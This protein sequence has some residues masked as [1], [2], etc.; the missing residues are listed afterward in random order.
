MAANSNI[1]LTSLDFDAL[2]TNF[3]TYLQGQSAFKDY[4]FQGS[5][6][7]TLVDLLTYNTQYNAYYLNMVANE[8]FLD[9]AVQRSSVVSQAKVLNYVPKSAIAPTATVNITFNNVTDASLTLPAYLNFSSS[10]IN[11][12]NYTFI[13]P[14]ANT[15]SV[16]NNIATFT[17]IPIKQ[18]VPATY[19]FTVDSTTNPTYTFEIPDN[20]IDTTTIQVLVQASASNSSYAIFNLATPSSYITLNPTSQVYFLQEGVNGNYQIYFGDGTLGQKLI[21]GNIV[22]VRYVSTEGT[23]AA[24]ANSFVLLNTVS[25][26]AASSVI[27]VTPATAGADKESIDSI[28]FQAPKSYAAQGRAVTKD[29]YITLI[30]QNQYVALDAVNVWGGEDNTPP[31]YGTVYV[32]VKP[33][34]GYSL[35][36]AQKVSLVS[37]VI[38]PISVITVTPKIIDV[39]YVYLLL[40]ANVLYDPKK[41][42]KTSA[43][44]SNLVT[45]GIQTFANA[46]LNTF[47]STFVVGNLIQY[48][49]S[50]DPSIIAAD[51][52]L[53]LQKRLIPTLGSTQTYTVNFGNAL[54]KGTGQHTLTIT[55][56]FS[57]YDSAGNFYENVFFEES[58][59]STTNIDYVTV[60]SGGTGYV[61]PTVT[62]SGDGTGATAVANV[63]NG[64]ITGISV[65][66]GGSGYTQAIAVITDAVGSGAIATPVLRG[67]YS[68]LRTY[69][70]VNGVKNILTGA[71]VNHADNAGSVDYTNGIV[72]LSNFT[73]VALSGTDGILRVNAYSA[74]RTVSSN[75]SRIIT[76]DTNDAA[77]ITVNVTAK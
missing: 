41:T 47:N 28:K 60:S 33:K 39:D 19:S 20:A 13:N 71:G 30:Q 63:V 24:G 74:S 65:T 32:A 1:Q 43:E 56:S 76:L 6:L 44:I 72:V 31:E 17:N 34:G 15:V 53:F 36:E 18:G 77:A 68:N 58:L 66:S 3:L 23:A 26:Y 69:Y 48:I 64:V 42:T 22:I 37:D 21:D 40:T 7:N 75:Y 27:S 59:D 14:S 2:K 12:V 29:D 8:M 11:G 62:I 61:A 73:P 70:F 46:N 51:F 38:K 50:L 45:T 55:P 16:V 52:D 35:T 25:G 9:S 10:A 54:E 5:A 4:N 57:Q 49:Q 67:N